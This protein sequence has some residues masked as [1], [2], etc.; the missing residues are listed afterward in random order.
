MSL[1]ANSPTQFTTSLEMNWKQTRYRSRHPCWAGCDIIFLPHM[2][3]LICNGMIWTRLSHLDFEESADGEIR[4]IH[5]LSELINKEV[6]QNKREIFVRRTQ[7]RILHKRR[8]GLMG[9]S[10]ET[11]TIW[12]IVTGIY[13][14]RE[15]TVHTCEWSRSIT[16]C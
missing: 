6:I 10:I 16:D 12:D 8:I 15:D 1:V 4:R 11:D 3:Y 7:C 9:L 13:D 5:L 14:V 2:S